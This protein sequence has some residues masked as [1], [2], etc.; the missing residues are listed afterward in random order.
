M[1]LVIGGSG[2]LGEALV[3]RLLKDDKK[4]RIFDVIPPSFS[5]NKNIEFIKGDVSEYNTVE[6]VMR[7]CNV[8]YNTASLLPCSQAGKRFKTT[9]VIGTEN[10]LK[11]AKK[12]GI[13]KVIHISSSIVYGI[14]ESLNISE[15]QAVAPIGPYGRSKVAAE[16]VCIDYINKG[17]NIVIL[18]PR[19]IVGPGRLGLLTILFEWVS[20]GKNVYTIGSGK[21]I[22]QMVGVDDLVEACILASKNGKNGIYNIG[23]DNTPT[24]EELLNKLIKHSGGSS[25]I[26]KLPSWPAKFSLK[27]LDIFK[28]TPLGAE[29]YLIADKNY[30]LNCQKA[31]ADLGW[32][33]KQNPVD[34]INLAYDWYIKNE[35]N[36][37]KNNKSNFPRQVFLKIIKFF[38]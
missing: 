32:V 19:F 18:R 27:I 17:L 6:K 28:L 38:S 2:F 7:G 3:K 10:V 15:Q 24:V 14:P 13:N 31:I 30:V 11:A 22:F 37:N 20:E 21:N 34:M 12:L 23:A 25:K 5:V 26:V 16:K 4:V 35:D 33:P 9:N 8:V 36:C 1:D 29:H